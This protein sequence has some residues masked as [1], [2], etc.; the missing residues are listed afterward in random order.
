[1]NGSLGYQYRFNEKNSLSSSFSFTERAPNFQEL[2]AGGAH[3]ATG[4]F[5]QGD[6]KLTKERAYAFE[7]SYKK[8]SKKHQLMMNA[9][10][11]VF[12]NFIFL[13]PTGTV[14]A[15]SGLA[16]Y[17]YGQ[18][19]ALFYGA[20]VENKNQILEH[21]GGT[22]KLVTKFDIVR[23]KNTQTGKNLPRISPPRLSAG[24]EYAKDTWSSDIEVQYVAEQTL[25]AV[26][27][28]RTGS[29]Y[30]TNIGYHY[31]I[32]G[33]A[34]ALSI[35]TRVRNI[36]DVEARSHIST[37]KEIAPLPGRNFILGLQLQI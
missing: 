22:L 8:Q 31:D 18:A 12:N 3:L 30:L 7:L 4:T 25:T 5:E 19:N 37:L 14:D 24:L 10:S 35:F 33:S 27:E 6:S 16:V 36:F 29:Y 15:G 2:Y 17:E 13:N 21:D 11:Q 34:S 32:L 28:T 1:M 9:Y 26:N 20:D 23:A